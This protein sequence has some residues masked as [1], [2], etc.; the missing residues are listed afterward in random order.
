MTPPYRLDIGEGL[1]GVADL[2]EEI[3]RIYGY[4][5]IPETLLADALPPQ[6]GFRLQE[7]E[8][9]LRDVLA[10]LGLQEVITYRL[11]T[12]ERDG[13]TGEVEAAAP[14][15]RLANPIASDR[16]VMRRSLLSSVLET[17]ESN[18]RL[19]ERIAVFEIGPVYPLEPGAGLPKETPQLV[20]ALTGRR[21]LRAWPSDGEDG[22][23]DFYD[24]KGLVFQTLEGLHLPEVQLRPAEHPAFHPGTCAEAWAGERRLGVLGEIH[25]H[26]RDR[27]DLGEAPVL[28]AEL[29]LAAVL[30][31]APDRVNTS[32]VPV[33]PP[34]LEDLAFIVDEDVP[35]GEVEAQ[36][37]QAGGLLLAEVRLFDVF[38]GGQI[39]E[40]K[41]SL[42]YSLVYQA[43]DRTLTDEEIAG[44]RRSLIARLEQAVGA[45]LRG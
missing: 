27:F 7:L 35:A 39:G 4:D 25:P 5:R 40:G 34:A 17:V 13:R 10:G 20:V 28:A 9:E 32:P 24:L 36:L 18:H 21:H 15:V 11:T 44:V 2:V 8:E 12:P 26:V 31:S 38:R 6:R 45:K 43:A 42:A 41:K 37:R 22:R 19:R 3:A 1:I 14:Y 16:V 29:D 30:E 33:Y 23:L